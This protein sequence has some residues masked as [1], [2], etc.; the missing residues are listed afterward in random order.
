MHCG[1]APKKL[2]EKTSIDLTAS[3]AMAAMKPSELGV[4]EPTTDIT[5]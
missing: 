3:S 5:L 4:S 1:H 2:A